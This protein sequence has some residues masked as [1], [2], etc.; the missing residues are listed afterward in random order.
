MD[1]KNLITRKEL[2]EIMSVT[3]EY[4]TTQYSRQGKRIREEREAG[5]PGLP[6]PGDIPEHAVK[7]DGKPL[8][9]RETILR[10]QATRP[11]PGRRNRRNR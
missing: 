5:L 7:L 11:D 4:V 8:W 10:W 1:L 2:A 6:K 9:D 3:P